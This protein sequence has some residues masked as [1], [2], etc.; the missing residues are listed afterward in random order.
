[1]TFYKILNNIIEI[2]PPTGLLTLPDTITQ[3][4]QFHNIYLDHD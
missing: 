3:P 2:N 4:T 1:M